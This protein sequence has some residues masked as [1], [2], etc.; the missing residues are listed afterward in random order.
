LFCDEFTNFN[1]VPVG[2]A[3]IR[4]LTKLGLEV[5][6]PDHLESGRTYLSK[7]M[8]KKSKALAME[9]IKLLKDLVSD[10]NP[11]IGIEPSA[12][13]S[14]RDE[15]PNFALG[16]NLEEASNALAENALL[17]D[18][19]LDQLFEKGEI[20][21]GIFSNRDKLIKLHGHCHQKSIASIV[22]TK[23]MLSFPEQL[24]KLKSSLLGVAEWLA[25]SDTKR[26]IMRYPCKLESWNFFLP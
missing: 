11:L 26:S 25:L 5:T 20:D 12:I 17:I 7:G 1:D 2:I 24:S 8:L 13:L 16:T 3:A 18:E 6:I 19:F 14:F 22:P 23:R 9:N 15:Y 21:K 10:E 4:L